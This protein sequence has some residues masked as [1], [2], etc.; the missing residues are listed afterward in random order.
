MTTGI[1]VDS[2]SAIFTVSY[3]AL[4]TSWWV[5]SHWSFSSMDGNVHM[6]FFAIS[7]ILWD[8]RLG[9]SEVGVI[10][11]AGNIAGFSIDGAQWGA[12][13]C[14]RRRPGRG[15]CLGLPTHALTSS[16]GCQ[17]EWMAPRANVGLRSRSAGKADLSPA[18]CPSSGEPSDGELGPSA[19]GHFQGAGHPSTAALLSL[20]P[21]AMEPPTP[22]KGQAWRW[23]NIC[24]VL[25]FLKNYKEQRMWSPSQDICP[26]FLRR[27]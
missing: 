18:S 13:R 21:S 16:L 14:C 24:V 6:L 23:K 12:L 10:T 9:Y 7:G 2:Q 26:F 22:P 25:Q 8:F 11:T 17:Q 20:A 3:F 27:K 1:Q 4:A 19:V 15:A 5:Y